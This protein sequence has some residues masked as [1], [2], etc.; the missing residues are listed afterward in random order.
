MQQASTQIKVT[1]VGTIEAKDKE[2]E[3]VGEESSTWIQK[4]EATLRGKIDTLAAREKEVQQLRE[5]LR[6][7]RKNHGGCPPRSKDK[8]TQS[9]HIL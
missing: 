5:Q 3:Q 8:K 6:R 7:W 2:I 1:R 4:L 9:P